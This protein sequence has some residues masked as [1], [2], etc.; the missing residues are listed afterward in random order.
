MLGPILPSHVDVA[1]QGLGNAPREL[2][3]PVGWQGTYVPNLSDWQEGDIVLVEG[4]GLS[5]L[6]IRG[7]Q[8]ITYNLRML[9]GAKW[10]HAAVYVGSGMVVDATNPAG[11]TEQSLWNYCS[12]RAIAVR[13]LGDP[14]TSAAAIR[15]IAHRARSHV[16]ESY[17]SMQALF[18]A[19][20]IP[21]ANTPNPAEL[22]CSTF[23]GLAVA[24][25]TGIRL[26]S[27][28]RHQ[29]LMPAILA[30]HVDLDSVQL[31]WRNT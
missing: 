1:A 25:A 26:W 15:D 3:V 11:V 30:T 7:V 19:L 13:R 24:E 27:D 9:M 5:G 22:I 31:E 21:V 10:S 17:S 23:A 14:T 28:P 12:R 18:S 6:A 8:S 20:R 16:G 4:T 29:P 2:N